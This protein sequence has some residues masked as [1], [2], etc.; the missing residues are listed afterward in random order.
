MTFP[1]A[2]SESDAAYDVPVSGSTVPEIPNSFSVDTR[3]LSASNPAQWCTAQSG[4]D[5]GR[6]ARNGAKR[7]G[8]LGLL[9]FESVR[10]GLS[11][12]LWQAPFGALR[13]AL[14]IQ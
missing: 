1:S 14:V 8:R 11:Q 12:A 2:A 6:G 4:V 10:D 3:V 5:P 7:G 13:E 9:A